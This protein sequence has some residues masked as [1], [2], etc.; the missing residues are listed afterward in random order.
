MGSLPISRVGPWLTMFALK[1][2]NLMHIFKSSLG[3]GR[4]RKRQREKERQTQRQ[5]ETG[6]CGRKQ[7]EQGGFAGTKIGWLSR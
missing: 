3:V 2:S 1:K 6:A 4:G 7:G 5:K